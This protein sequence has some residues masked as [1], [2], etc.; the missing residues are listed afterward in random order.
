MAGFRSQIYPG[1]RIIDSGNSSSVVNVDPVQHGRG[2]FPRQ[3]PFGSLGFAAP[4]E[5]PLVDRAEWPDRIEFMEKTNTRLSDLVNDA[6]LP[7]KDQNGTNYCWSNAPAHCVEIVRV[8]QGA[9][10]VLLSPASVG[11]KI[12]GFRNVGG[13]GSEALHFITQNGVVPTEHW[14]ANAIHPEFD[15]DEAWRDAERFKVV[16]WWDIPPRD[17]DALFAALFA[18]VP[19]AVGFNWWGHEVTAYDPVKLERGYGVR[20]RNSWGMGW[21]ESGYSILKGKRALPDDAVA[22]R[23]ATPNAGGFVI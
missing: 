19:V 10:V 15:T 9:P 5:L 17:L 6:G 23:V 13:W 21:G 8:L 22:P 1:E 3:E 7:C 11:A 2:L 18:R 14:P 16:E 20:I 4:S 12:K